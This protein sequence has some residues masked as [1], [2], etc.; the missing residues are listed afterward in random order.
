MSIHF[1]P[2]Q[3]HEI[4]LARAREKGELS[5][6]TIHDQFADA[7][8]TEAIDVLRRRLSLC[9]CP[10]ESDR[11]LKAL[12]EACYLAGAIEGAKLY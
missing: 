8:G 5:A 9:T 11:W 4:R 3:S 2:E 1:S 12:G 6:Q 7:W 10:E